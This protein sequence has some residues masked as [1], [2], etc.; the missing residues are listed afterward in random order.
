MGGGR[1][2]FLEKPSPDGADPELWGKRRQMGTVR[3][4]VA[5]EAPGA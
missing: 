5:A 3:K 1:L 2:G 4:E